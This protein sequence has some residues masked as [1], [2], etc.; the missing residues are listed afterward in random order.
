MADEAALVDAARRGDRAA[1][2]ELVQRYS[3]AVIARHYAATHSL[4]AA[5]DLAQETFLRAVEDL[6]RLKDVR[7]FG[8]WILSIADN[9]AREWVRRKRTRD[10]HRDRV[11]Q[12]LAPPPSGPAREPDLPIAEA[13]AALTPDLQQLLALRHDHNLSCEEIAQAT[14][15]PLGSVTKMLSRAYEELRARLGK[16]VN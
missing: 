6:G 4:P 9:V 10:G 12:A 5:E 1:L 11:E 8:S 14:G 15:R 16:Q 13:V 3:R 2:G 7:A